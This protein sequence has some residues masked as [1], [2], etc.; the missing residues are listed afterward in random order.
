[1]PVAQPCKPTALLGE[2]P[3]L[4]NSA[5]VQFLHT[6]PW[7]LAVLCYLPPNPGGLGC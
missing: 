6:S 5:S 1:M 4:L 2:S 7:N 3:G